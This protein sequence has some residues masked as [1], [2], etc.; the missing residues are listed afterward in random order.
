MGSVSQEGFAALHLFMCYGSGMSYAA[1]K[2]LE[3]TYVTYPTRHI[4]FLG[5]YNLFHG[6]RFRNFW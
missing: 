2:F 3:I 1:E 5:V 4:Q 6:E